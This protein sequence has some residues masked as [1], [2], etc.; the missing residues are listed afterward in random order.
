MLS[1]F[2]WLFFFYIGILCFALLRTINDP[3]CQQQSQPLSRRYLRPSLDLR[4]FACF[5]VYVRKIFF[6]KARLNLE[7]LISMNDVYYLL[8]N[9]MR[10]WG[11]GGRGEFPHHPAAG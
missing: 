7:C 10:M 9:R 1:S 2:C 5:I 6:S 4:L 11:L 3:S 8:S